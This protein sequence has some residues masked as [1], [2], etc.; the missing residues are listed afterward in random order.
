MELR[1]KK[2]LFKTS[3]FL[4][5]VHFIKVHRIL[6]FGKVPT[7][8]IFWGALLLYSSSFTNLIEPNLGLGLFGFG[9]SIWNFQKKKN[10]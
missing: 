1:E 7:Y 6:D 2:I 10:Y 5:S 9:L 4:F 3:V 8:L